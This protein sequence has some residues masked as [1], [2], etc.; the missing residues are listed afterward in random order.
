MGPLVNQVFGTA[1]TAIT[2]D[3]NP[4]GESTLGNLIADAQLAATK[5]RARRL[6]S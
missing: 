3:E 4:A 2:R 5:A 6:P 1:A